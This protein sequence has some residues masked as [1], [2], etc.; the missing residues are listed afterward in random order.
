[1]T[2]KKYID[3][4]AWLRQCNPSYMNLNLAR[5]I[6]AEAPAAPVFGQWISAEQ[7]PAEADEYI[8]MIAGAVRPTVLFF[9]HNEDGEGEWLEEV[10]DGTNFYKVT[11]W[12]ALPEGP[13]KCRVQNAECRVEDAAFK[14]PNV[15]TCK[16]CGAEIVWVTM[17]SGKKMPC[18]AELIGFLEKNDAQTV[19][20]RP[21]KGIVM[22]GVKAPTDM[23]CFWGYRSHFETCP[24]GTFASAAGGRRSEQKGVAAVAESKGT[25]VT[26][27]RCGNGNRE[28]QFRKRGQG[29][30]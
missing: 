5:K 10:E 24:Q 20:I 16:A 8:V 1:M 30:G 25:N 27:A 15:C 7:P 17:Q 23:T 22:R 9:A 6:I 18:D 11:H 29:D 13:G 19:F 4:T 14:K 2:E 28:D 26:D 21:D 3:A 12:M